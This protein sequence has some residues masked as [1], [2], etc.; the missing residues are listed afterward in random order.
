MEIEEKKKIVEEVLQYP[1]GNISD[2]MDNLGIRRGAIA[3]V[4]ALDPKQK[5]AAGFCAY[6]P[7]GT[8]Q[9]GV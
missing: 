8:S 7:S 1:T 9:H 5:K 2:A 6:D 3:G 4:H